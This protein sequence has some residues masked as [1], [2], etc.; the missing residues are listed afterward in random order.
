VLGHESIFEAQALDGR[1]VGVES[2]VGGAVCGGVGLV[3]FS[4]GCHGWCLVSTSL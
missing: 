2:A 3:P 4:F 1:P